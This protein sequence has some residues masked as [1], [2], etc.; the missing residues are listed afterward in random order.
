MASD[1][2]GGVLWPNRRFS[3][4]IY[5]VYSTYTHLAV[6]QMS[7]S[8]TDIGPSRCFSLCESGLLL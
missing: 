5:P 7:D 3:M 8:C 4:R 2:S 6:P 1:V